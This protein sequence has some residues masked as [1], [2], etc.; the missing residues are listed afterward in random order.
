MIDSILTASVAELNPPIDL[1][2]LF[3]PEGEETAIDKMNAEMLKGQNKIPCR[4]IRMYKSSSCCTMIFCDAAG[5]RI[6]DSGEY[7]TEALW[8]CKTANEMQT[9]AIMQQR[10]AMMAEYDEEEDD[11]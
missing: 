2:S 3:T 4:M 11:D 1:L 10:D 6:L 9:A 8:S 5:L 7:E